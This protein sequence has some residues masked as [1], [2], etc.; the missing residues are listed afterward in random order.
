MHNVW[1]KFNSSLF[2]EPCPDPGHPR[3]GNRIG[4]DFR[5][6]KSVIFTCSGDY[7]M[8]GV[9][10][11]TCADGRWSNEKPSCKGKFRFFFLFS[12]QILLSHLAKDRK[13]TD[14]TP[15]GLYFLVPIRL[16]NLYSNQV[17]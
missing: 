11:I 1:F 3:Q 12:R 7:V 4:G 9:R 17:T 14:K 10:T 8:E 16:H 6:G 13:E 2:S 15:Y 5:H